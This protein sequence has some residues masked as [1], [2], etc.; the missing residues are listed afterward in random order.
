MKTMSERVVNIEIEYEDKKIEKTGRP[1]PEIIVKGEERFIHDQKDGQIVEK[2]NIT[3]SGILIYQ[4]IKDQNYS[5]VEII[6]YH[7]IKTASFVL[8]DDD[9]LLNVEEMKF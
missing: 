2:I 6:P 4:R 1:N 7:T 8:D 3:N 9:T 5:N